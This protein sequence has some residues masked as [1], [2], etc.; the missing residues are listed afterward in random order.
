MTRDIVVSTWEGARVWRRLTFAPTDVAAMPAATVVGWLRYVGV[1]VPAT[2]QAQR[3]RLA[4]FPTAN[5]LDAIAAHFLAGGDGVKPTVRVVERVPSRRASG[6]G[7]D[8]GAAGS[9]P[10][11]R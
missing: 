11:R 6:V 10:R 3:E 9:V 1:T 4:A 8:L 2:E 5:D 7:L